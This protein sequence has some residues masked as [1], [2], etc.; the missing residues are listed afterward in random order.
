MI[1][2]KVGDR[3]RITRTWEGTI[4]AKGRATPSVALNGGSFIGLNDRPDSMVSVEV[5]EPE[6]VVGEVYIDA[7]NDPFIRR[8][9]TQKPWRSPDGQIWRDGYPTRPLRLFAAEPGD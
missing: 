4:T 9:D 7:D 3:V 1:E 5:L 6:Y 2:Y 8:P